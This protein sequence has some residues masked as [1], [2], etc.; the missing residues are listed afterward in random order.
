M[1]QM[2]VGL[3]AV[4]VAALVIGVSLLRAQ[5]VEVAEDAEAPPAKADIKQVSYIIGINI[6]KNFKGQAIDVDVDSFLEGLRDGLGGK[7]GRITQQEMQKVMKAFEEEHVA[8]QMEKARIMA[9]ENKTRGA[10]FLE[11]NKKKEGVKVTESGLQ[12]RVIKE[13]T[14]KQPKATDSVTVHYKGTL[15]DGKEFDSSYSRGEPVTFPLNN[16]IRGWTEALQLMREG[17]KYQ[18]ALPPELAYGERGASTDIGPN[19]VLVF[20]IELIKVG[21][22][23]PEE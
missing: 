5:D 16:V 15:I 7:E 19:A 11:E 8:R 13:G 1:K 18:I 3:G 12:Y 20:D 23:E 21:E 14:G 4:L 9:E 17:A 10:A 6:G 2:M 22:G